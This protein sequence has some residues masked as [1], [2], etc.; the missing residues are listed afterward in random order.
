MT[1]PKIAASVGLVA[2]LALGV[3]SI[4]SAQG[5]NR[6]HAVPR[7]S[8]RPSR[9]PVTVVPYRNYYYRS[10]RPSMNLA[11]FYGYPGYYGSYAYGYVP[12]GYNA[13]QYAPPYGYGVS[14]YAGRPYGGVRIVLPQRDAEVFADGYFVGTVNDFD[15]VLQ[16]ANLEAG[17]HHI[18]VRAPGFEPIEF[19]VNVE[20]GRTITFRSSM[21][22]LQP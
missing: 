2:A 12:Y 15:G 6:G 21:R 18:E 9:P 11:F 13:Y 19:D 16:Q 14:G 5:R 7:G 17:P 20:P 22:L 3:S 10:Y 1:Y 8:V 4:A